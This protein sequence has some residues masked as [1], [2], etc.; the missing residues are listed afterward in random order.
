MIK[1]IIAMLT[2]EREKRNPSH[3]VQQE[4]IEHENAEERRQIAMQHQRERLR[5]NMEKRE[6]PVNPSSIPSDSEQA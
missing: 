4:A 3:F 5:D 6:E 1:K 2:G